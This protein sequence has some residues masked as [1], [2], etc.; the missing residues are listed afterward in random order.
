MDACR[1]WHPSSSCTKK[2]QTLFPG[3]SRRQIITVKHNPLSLHCTQFWFCFQIWYLCLN[4]A[5]LFSGW[6]SFA[7]CLGNIYSI[8]SVSVAN[9]AVGNVERENGNLLL[10]M[11]IMWAVLDNTSETFYKFTL[12][13]IVHLFPTLQC[14]HAIWTITYLH[15]YTI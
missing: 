1:S 9:R 3:V 6:A 15:V 14:D 7:L 12:S 5:V 4:V 8:W 13:K 11:S 2:L 10:L